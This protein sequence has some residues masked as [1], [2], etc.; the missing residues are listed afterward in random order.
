MSKKKGSKNRPF[1][2]FSSEWD[3]IHTHNTPILTYLTSSLQTSLQN[4][5]K[6]EGYEKDDYNNLIISLLVRTVANSSFRLAKEI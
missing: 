1:R 4:Q 3:Y 6:R 2:I 5:T